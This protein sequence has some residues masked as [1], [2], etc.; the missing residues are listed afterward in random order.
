M[1]T[2]DLIAALAADNDSREMA[3]ASALKLGLGLGFAVSVLFFFS[4]LGPHE[5]FI[6]SLAS[7]RFLFKFLFAF[8]TAGVGLAL[9]F[10]LARPEREPDGYLWALAIPLV[11]LAL[12]CLAEFFS[13]P[14]EN[15]WAR[16]I[17]HNAV[18]CL[19]LVPVMALG[20]LAGVVFGLRH[21]APKNPALAGAAAGFGAS[22]LSAALYAANCPDDS[23][24]FLAVWYILAI[25]ISVVLGRFAGGRLL[26]W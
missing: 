24:F 25:A 14:R 12:A 4:F 23:P 19:T 3:P 15:Y 20:P 18:H 16:M 17:G 22:G 21:G 13:V 5:N 7:P 10:R 9:A 2:E 26:R 1:K 8:S 6:A 11:M